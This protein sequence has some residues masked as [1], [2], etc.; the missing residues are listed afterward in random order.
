[1]AI[2][3]GLV[4]IL[5]LIIGSFL[6]VCIYRIPN[7]ES[8]A[9]PPSNCNSCSID[10]KWYDLIPVVSYV[11][12]GGKCRGC[13]EKI[14]MQYPIIEII[15]GICFVLLYSQ[16]DFTPRFFMFAGLTA[17][18]IVTAAIDYN[19]GYIYEKVSMVGIVVAIIYVGYTFYIG[20]NYMDLLLGSVAAG[21]IIAVFAMFKAMGWGDVEL[22]VVCGLF[23]GFYKGMLML[24]I[25]IILGGIVGSYILLTKQ[26]QRGSTM[27]FG[28]FISI[29]GFIA[30]LYGEVIIEAIIRY[31][32]F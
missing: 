8:I 28:P 27:A 12:L 9:Y 5:G 24:F 18:L 4:F 31:Y 29:G 7:E 19:T 20:G 2:Y 23:L 6:N 30:L 17:V 16:Y 13:K 10:I 22:T 11:Y 1:M 15:T 21:G 3:Y 14:S 25:A 26:K 32:G